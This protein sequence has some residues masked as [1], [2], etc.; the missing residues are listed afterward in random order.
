[1]NQSAAAPSSVAPTAAQAVRSVI[2][3]LDRP[4]H[5]QRLRKARQ[6][7][8]VEM[9]LRSASPNDKQEVRRW[10][11]C[12]EAIAILHGVRLEN[13]EPTDQERDR[14]L[15][16]AGEMEQWLSPGSRSD[17][18][19]EVEYADDQLADWPLE[20]DWSAPAPLADFGNRLGNMDW[21]K[22][23][24]IAERYWDLIRVSRKF[25]IVRL[26]KMDKL[27]RQRIEKGI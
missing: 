16:I 8:G 20:G 15:A 14:L 11:M 24:E 18:D 4:Y 17:T 7:V 21:R 26:D 13:A 9:I 27:T 23:K 22:F 3:R 12:N 25:W 6:Y 5:D 19:K 2:E 10:Q 1:M